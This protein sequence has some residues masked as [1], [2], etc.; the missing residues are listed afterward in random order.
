M[1]P[2]RRRLPLPAATAA[3]PEW[4]AL[5]L[6]VA[7]WAVMLGDVYRV[8]GWAL[9]LASA[10]GEQRGFVDN[11]QTAWRTG[12]LTAVLLSWGVMTLAMMPVLA[13]P[14]IR[15]VAARTFV[16]RRHRAIAGFLAGMLGVWLLVGLAALTTLG[17]LPAALSS[18]PKAAAAAFL[19]A[20]A[21]QLTPMKRSALARCHRTLPLAATGWPADRDCL[22]YGLAHGLDCVASC[23]AIMLAMAVGPHSPVIGLGILVIALREQWS[24]RTA[25]GMPALLFAGFA[26]LLLLRSLL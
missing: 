2:Y 24:A 7:A 4:W 25:V 1:T 10:P 16:T 14:P 19:L 23:W 22:R 17:A 6:S 26:L 20:A 11:L 13:V 18:D 3:H 21:W 9:C 12:A 15:Y 8:H 5:L